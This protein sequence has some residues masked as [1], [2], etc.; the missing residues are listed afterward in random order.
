MPAWFSE[1]DE[2]C[3]RECIRLCRD[4][5]A[6]TGIKWHVDHM[7]PLRAKVASGLHV[8]SNLQVIP[9]FLNG[10]KKNKMELTMAD[11]WLHKL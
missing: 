11:E 9:A 7:I 8:G 3:I 10:W 4:R 6:A 2:F 5:L 1:L